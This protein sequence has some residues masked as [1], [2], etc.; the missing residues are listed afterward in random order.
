MVGARLGCWADFATGD[1]GGDLISLLAYLRGIS[2]S[3]AARLL[4]Q[5]LDI[6]L[7]GRR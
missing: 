1:Q 2:Q 6:E 7:E 3:E 5:M 4:A